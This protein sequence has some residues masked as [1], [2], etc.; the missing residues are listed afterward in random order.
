MVWMIE[1]KRVMVQAMIQSEL[2]FLWSREGWID[3]SIF[4]GI[5]HHR[6]YNQCKFLRHFSL[7]VDLSDVTDS[8][9]Q[10]HSW[11]M[12]GTNCRTR[13]CKS[14]YVPSNK[15]TDSHA[16]KF[17]DMNNLYV[18]VRVGDKGSTGG[19]EIQD[20]MM[21]TAKG[22]TAGV[23]LMEWNIAQTS[24]GEA[25]MWGKLYVVTYLQRSR[26]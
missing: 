3:L 1:K 14:H 19:M 4:Y 25:A 12:L 9:W 8:H 13:K 22:A 17:A 18:A 23:I 6:G 26:S 16:Q 24:T 5:V 10:W 7:R 15:Q 21:F 2:T 11:W 20:M